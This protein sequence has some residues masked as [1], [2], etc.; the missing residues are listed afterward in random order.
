MSDPPSTAHRTLVEQATAGEP[1]AIDELIERH[2]PR[3]VEF[4]RRRADQLVL[5]KES[6][7]DLVQ[8][9]CREVLEEADGFEY[10]G[11]G[12]FVSW[13]HRIALSKIIDKYRYHRAEKRDPGREVGLGGSSSA[14]TTG[15]A[16]RAGEAT[17]GHVCATFCTPSEM[18]IKN[19][20]AGL[21][22][23]AFNQLSEEYQEVLFLAHIIG[24]PHPEIAQQMG[25]SADATR[26][27]LGRARARLGLVLQSLREG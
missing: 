10:R 21:V 6:L 26:S 5:A 22:A 4:L 7:T 2:Y 20:Q 24:W 25:R 17:L 11:E 15:G 1:V 14:T 19:E 18:A 12:Q 23:E 16:G 3:L 8:S 13:L 27:L 9:V